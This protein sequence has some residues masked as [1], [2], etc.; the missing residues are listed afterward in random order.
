MHQRLTLASLLPLPVVVCLVLV[1]W[2]AAGLPLREVVVELPPEAEV[3]LFHV[4]PE[5]LDP[6]WT[7]PPAMEARFVLAFLGIGLI[8]GAVA[9]LGKRRVGTPP[10]LASA[11]VLGMCA[12]VLT[13]EKLHT[14]GPS[15]LFIDGEHSSAVEF[16]AAVS[17][18][19]FA[20]A[21]LVISVWAG[22]GAREIISSRLRE[23]GRRAGAAR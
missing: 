7:S 10:L 23:L 11:L 8:I 20:A 21:V 6:T 18:Y 9:G 2:A 14:Y 5:V 12:G 13:G 22:A 4:K 3:S 19:A 15:S 17:G 16:D 1:G